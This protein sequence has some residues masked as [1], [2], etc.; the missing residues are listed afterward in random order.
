MKHNHT[1]ISPISD[2]HPF[3]D[4]LAINYACSC[5]NTFN[6]DFSVKMIFGNKKKIP[7]LRNLT[8]S[9]SVP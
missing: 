1:K 3:I 5:L 6:T 2:I 8:I 4:D 7:A 9:M